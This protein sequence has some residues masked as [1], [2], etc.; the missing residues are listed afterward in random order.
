M[1]T[2]LST[3]I[4]GILSLPII[5]P[6]LMRHKQRTATCGGNEHPL[7]G[8]LFTCPMTGAWQGSV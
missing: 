1:A 3:E 6:G 8:Y 5:V 7:I 4:T 2:S